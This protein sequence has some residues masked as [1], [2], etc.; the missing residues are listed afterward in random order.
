MLLKI[1]IAIIFH[2]CQDEDTQCK[3]LR[4]FPHKAELEQERYEAQF[5][6]ACGCIGLC[7]KISLFYMTVDPHVAR[8][9]SCVGKY[10]LYFILLYF[11]IF[12]A[13][14]KLYVVDCDQGSLL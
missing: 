12:L 14:Y 4:L 7:Y 3:T 13:Y 11:M 1:Y 6:K 8:E 5:K 10:Y 2:G 9:A